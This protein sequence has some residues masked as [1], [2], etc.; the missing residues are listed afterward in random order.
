MVSG[1]QMTMQASAFQIGPAFRSFWLT[2]DI[3]NASTA[4]PGVAAGSQAVLT[5]GSSPVP[6]SVNGFTLFM[7]DRSLPITAAAN[8]QITF[9]IPAGTA[10]GGA[11]LRLEAAGERSLPILMIIDPPAPRILSAVSDGEPPSTFK[12]G[13]LVA[14]MVSD[15]ESPGTA[16]DIPRVSVML[17]GATASVAQV[18]EQ[19]DSHRVLVYA[20]DSAPTGND[21]PLTVS[22][23]SRV[24]D[25]IT[26]SVEN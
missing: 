1:L 14:V 20:P 23:D 18:L 21:L 25:P 16:L 2:S 15:L 17:G 12:T 4:A 5:I 6:V 8:N 10:A 19:V 11:I 24:S 7:N 22:I 26:V 9:Q 13:Q 3:L